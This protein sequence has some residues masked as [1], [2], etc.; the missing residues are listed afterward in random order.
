MK[1]IE[2]LLG[3]VVLTGPLFLIVIWLPVCVWIALILSKR[4]HH[5]PA[6]I[7]GGVGIFFMLFIFP[8]SDQIIGKIYHN[9]LCNNKAGVK[10]YQTIELPAEYWD[11]FGKPRFISARGNLE[12]SLL[13]YRYRNSFEKAT[14]SSLFGIDK[15]RQQVINYETKEVIGEVVNYMYWGGMISRNLSP[16]SG[17]VDCEDFHGNEFWA[18]FYS[19]LFRRP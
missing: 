6:K 2:E 10:V 4:F 1:F 15:Y 11:E 14:Y 8:F 3:F 13:S 12:V 18:N 19:S 17:A 5:R 7:A 9:Y 16:A